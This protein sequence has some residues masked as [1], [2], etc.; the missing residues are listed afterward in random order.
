M[1]RHCYKGCLS[2]QKQIVVAVFE[3]MTLLK[4]RLA[5][6]PDRFLFSVFSVPPGPPPQ[7]KKRVIIKIRFF[8]AL[9]SVSI[10]IYTHIHIWQGCGYVQID[11][12]AQ[13]KVGCLS[14]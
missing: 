4:K 14:R 2:F 11:D 7:K 9:G 12:S 13:K 1:L 5:V 10:Y 6:F 3:R 8:F